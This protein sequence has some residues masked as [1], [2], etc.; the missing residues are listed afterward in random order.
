M[1]S[2]DN[3]VYF[4]IGAGVGTAA[5][6]LYAPRSGAE[7]RAYLRDQAMQGAVYIE[8]TRGTAMRTLRDKVDQVKK[9]ASDVIAK[10]GGLKDTVNEAVEVGKRAYRDVQDAALES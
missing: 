7:T 8:E 5:A 4:L 3:M 6:L 10:T 9:T 2:K 1:S